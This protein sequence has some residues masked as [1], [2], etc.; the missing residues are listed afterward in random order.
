MVKD[1]TGRDGTL[2]NAR[3][4]FIRIYLNSG[5]NADVTKAKYYL[6]LND[7]CQTLLSTYALFSKVSHE[8]SMTYTLQLN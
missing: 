6:V 3:T 2:P 1:E 4:V 7:I 8:F 5:K